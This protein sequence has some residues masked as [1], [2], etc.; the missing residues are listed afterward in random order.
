MLP[1]M[2]VIELRSQKIR[3]VLLKERD[4][5]LETIE[6]IIQLAERLEKKP[7]LLR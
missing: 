2:Y 3:Q 1:Y 4:P 7:S 5:D 6:K